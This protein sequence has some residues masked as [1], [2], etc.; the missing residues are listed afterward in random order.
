MPSRRRRIS[1]FLRANRAA[2]RAELRTIVETLAFVADQRLYFQILAAA[3]TLEE[4]IRKQSLHAFDDVF[5]VR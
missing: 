1:K 2:V 4:D 3:E 5:V